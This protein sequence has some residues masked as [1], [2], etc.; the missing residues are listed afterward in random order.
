MHI[1]RKGVVSCQLAGLT[2]AGKMIVDAIRADIADVEDPFDDCPDCQK[3][4]KDDGRQMSFQEGCLW[5]ESLAVT[6]SRTSNEY[7]SINVSSMFTTLD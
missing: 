4:H 1:T 2:P 3:T 6:L 5:A 7:H